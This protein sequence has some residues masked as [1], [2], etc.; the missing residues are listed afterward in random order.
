MVYFNDLIGNSTQLHIMTYKESMGIKPILKM[1][2]VCFKKL[3]LR[4]KG[5]YKTIYLSFL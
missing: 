4:F 5:K 2:L 3:V 1:Y